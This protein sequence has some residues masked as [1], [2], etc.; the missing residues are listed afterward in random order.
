MNKWKYQVKCRCRHLLGSI[1]KWIEIKLNERRRRIKSLDLLFCRLVSFFLCFSVWSLYRAP[2]KVAEQRLFQPLLVLFFITPNVAVNG[3]A[4]PS[5]LLFDWKGTPEQ[6]RNNKGESNLEYLFI[7]YL[8]LLLPLLSTF[9]FLLFYGLWWRHLP[10]D[11]NGIN[12]NRYLD[13][14]WRLPT[15]TRNRW[16]D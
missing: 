10:T 4:K 13:Q 12:I 9:S 14:V 1:L 11:I 5:A 15:I 7:C 8:L 2:Q 16:L 3:G 6:K